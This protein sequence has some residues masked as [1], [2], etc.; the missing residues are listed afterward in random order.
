MISIFVPITSHYRAC[1]YAF[2]AAL[3]LTSCNRNPIEYIH[4]G[5]ALLAEGKYAD[6]ELNFRKALQNSPKSGE[7]VYGLAQTFLK[8][9]RLIEGYKSLEEASRLLPARSD[10]KIA[11]ADVALGM[12]FLDQRQKNLYDQISKISQDLIAKNSKSMDGWRLKGYLAIADRN[13]KDAIIAFRAAGAQEVTGARVTLGLCQAL[14]Q[15]NQFA[16]A[17]I[18]GLRLLEKE[19][20]YLPAYDLFYYEYLRI[21][22]HA[23]AAKLLERKVE[24]NPN[25]S[26]TILQLATHHSRLK[27]VSAMENVLKRLLDNPKS[28]P[29][30]RLQVGDFYANQRLWPEALRHYE[31]GAQSDSEERFLYYRKL[32]TLQNSLGNKA[33]A[34]RNLNL[35]LKKT[36][37]DKEARALRAAIFLDSAKAED[38]NVA[39]EELRALV[40]DRKDDASLHANLGRAFLRKGNLGEARQSFSQALRLRP[41][42]LTPRLGLAEVSLKQGKADDA[43]KYADEILAL[44][45]QNAQARLLRAVSFRIGGMYTEARAELGRLKQDSVNWREVELESAMLALMEKRYQDA[46]QAFRKLEQQNSAGKHPVFGLADVYLA[47]EKFE[48]AVTMVTAQVNQN[49]DSW[50]LRNLLATVALRA[51]KYDLAQEQYRHMLRIAPASLETRLL[52]GEAYR[53][54]GD[55]V[56]ASRVFTEAAKVAPKDVTPLMMLAIAQHT[57]G[58]MEDAQKSYRRVLE[59]SPN[60][61]IAMNNLAFLLTEANADLNEAERLAQGAI[62]KARNQPNYIDTLGLI[63]LKK[64]LK[65]SAVQLFDNLVRQYPDTADYRYHFAMALVAKGDSSKAR[66]ELKLALGKTADQQLLEKIRAL[67][68]QIG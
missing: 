17:E 41:D 28:F 12:Y 42:Y 26:G 11:L 27:N 66:Q 58:R 24:N 60:N 9:D 51:R 34:L 62:Q 14:L 44:D 39:F 43:R 29:Q 33:E 57:A 36:P 2:T 19:K 25:D 64:G 54:Q 59:V 40:N 3:F 55:F 22:R 4:T 38:Q 35:V 63:Y 16:E 46:E 20:D 47:Q 5:E 10:V 50:P 48:Q 30:A 49:P 67:L 31:A 52:S 61:P 15:D 56:N 18:L 65:D 37:D 68:T 32:A 6:A 53:Q 23:D 45:K 13:P 1:I 8:R 21:N 7:A